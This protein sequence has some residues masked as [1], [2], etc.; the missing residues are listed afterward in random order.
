MVSNLIE[1]KG[2]CTALRHAV[3]PGADAETIRTMSAERARPAEEGGTSSLTETLLGAR[4]KLSTRLARCLLSE[5]CEPLRTISAEWTMQS[6][7]VE[8]QRSVCAS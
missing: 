8:R 4:R 1:N 5:A 2:Q 3:L 7:A 6:E